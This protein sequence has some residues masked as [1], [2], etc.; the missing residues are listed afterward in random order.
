[1]AEG[2]RTRFERHLP[3]YV[4]T[5]KSVFIL[6]AGAIG[7]WTAL[8]LQKLGIDN[9]NIWDHDLIEDANVG[10]QSYG[11]LDVGR[12]KVAVLKEQ[13]LLNAGED[14]IEVAVSPTRLRSNNRWLPNANIYIAAVDNVQAREVLWNKA[15]GTMWRSNTYAIFIDPRMGLDSFEIHAQMIGRHRLRLL[16]AYRA[17]YMA[18]FHRGIQPAACGLEAAPY[19]AIACAGAIGALVRTMLMYE[20]FPLYQRWNLG[21]GTCYRGTMIDPSADRLPRRRP[22]KRRLKEAV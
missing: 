22:V 8:M 18:S 2:L 13:L 5:G 14:R 6:G 12:R 20:E 4:I 10:V 21:E 16:R 11:K 17:E 7:S 19:T 15:H 9:F 3:D 1:M